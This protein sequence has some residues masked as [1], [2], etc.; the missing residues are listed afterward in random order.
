MEKYMTVKEVAVMVQL[1]EQTI[2]RYVM[3][4]QIPFHKI[5]R[6][7]RFKPSEIQIWVDENK[8]KLAE[9]KKADK[10]AG[11]FDEAGAKNE[12]L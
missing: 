8:A 7:V 9:S 11:L 12:G 5:I 1:S 10:E 6:A 3:L 2:R 4:K